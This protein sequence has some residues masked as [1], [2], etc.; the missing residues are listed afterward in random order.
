MKPVLYFLISALLIACEQNPRAKIPTTGSFGKA[1]TNTAPY[2]VE[3]ALQQFANSP[4]AEIT[5]TGV[6][7]DYCK[8]EGCW[9]TL[10]HAGAGPLFVE[11]KDNAFVLPEKINGKTAIVHGSMLMDS[12]DGKTFPKIIANGIIIK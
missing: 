2:T 7:A 12:V 6:I 9:L 3:V 5:V 10:E 1:I 4:Q 11:V 8:G